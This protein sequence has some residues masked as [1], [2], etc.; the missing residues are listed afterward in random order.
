MSTVHDCH[1][2]HNKLTT[3]TPQQNTTFP[4][5][6][7]KNAHK[8]I[9]PPR[10]PRQKKSRFLIPEKFDNLRLLPIVTALEM[11]EFPGES[12]P[13]RRDRAGLSAVLLK[14]VRIIFVLLS[15]AATSADAQTAVH[16]AITAIV[17]DST[18]APP[19]TPNAPH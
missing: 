2:F 10:S 4:K 15:L 19:P 12:L 8:S 14:I 1:P 6:P 3:K 13:F 7:L 5:T 17:T 9:K 11:L 16:R 18:H